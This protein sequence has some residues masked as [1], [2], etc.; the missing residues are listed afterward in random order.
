VSR[1]PNLPCKPTRRLPIQAGNKVAASSTSVTCVHV[2]GVPPYQRAVWPGARVLAA[3]SKSCHL[4]AR[5][6]ILFRQPA[7][8]RRE[9]KRAAWAWPAK[10][11]PRRPCGPARRIGSIWPARV[12]RPGSPSAGRAGNGRHLSRQPGRNQAH[13]PVKPS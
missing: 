9:S 7:V 12:R 1:S 11:R 8:P 3:R 10:R 6:G 2:T 4:I 5:G 13:G